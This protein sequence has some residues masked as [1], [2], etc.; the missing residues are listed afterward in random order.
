MPTFSTRQLLQLVTL[1][2]IAALSHAA[3][4]QSGTVQV[5][6]LGQSAMKVTTPGGKV[7]VIDPWL[8]EV[9]PEF[10]TGV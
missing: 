2:L 6:W 3:W 5:Q 8:I 1:W 10:G 4:A 9:D 7:I